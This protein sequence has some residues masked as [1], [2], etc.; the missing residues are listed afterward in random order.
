MINLELTSR[1]TIVMKDPA[2]ED[3]RAEFEMDA[4][5]Y[6]FD[7]KRRFCAAPEPWSEYDDALTG[8]RWAGWLAKA[9]IE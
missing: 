7:L 4:E 2:R 8:M 6:G 1:G 9:G 3:E 5:R